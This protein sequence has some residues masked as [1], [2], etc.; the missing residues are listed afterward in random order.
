MSEFMIT[1]R[2]NRKPTHPGAVL[3]EDVLPAMKESVTGFAVPVGMSRQSIY[4]IHGHK[5]WFI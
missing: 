5:L 3:R 4:A 2:P 1:H